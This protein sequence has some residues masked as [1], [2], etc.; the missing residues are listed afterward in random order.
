MLPALFFVIFYLP[1][2]RCLYCVRVCV[3]FGAF[4]SAFKV[5]F[6]APNVP[7]TKTHYVVILVQLLKH[8]LLQT[9]EVFCV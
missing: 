4:N 2:Q 3:L 1:S 8:K 7:T 5:S 6:C 9:I